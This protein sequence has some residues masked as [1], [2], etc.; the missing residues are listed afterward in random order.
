MKIIFGTVV[1]TLLS[2]SILAQD[3]ATHLSPLDKK[4]FVTAKS[5]IDR[6]SGYQVYEKRK[7]SITFIGCPVIGSQLLPRTAIEEVSVRTSGLSAQYVEKL[8][9]NLQ[10]R[11]VIPF[12]I[13]STRWK[14]S[15][16]SLKP[17]YDY[18]D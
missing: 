16:Y 3:R 15:Y 8:E 10:L 11:E 9:E 5:D 17:K 7:T 4:G 13:H 14:Y 18:Y 1:L 2:L 12:T 6:P